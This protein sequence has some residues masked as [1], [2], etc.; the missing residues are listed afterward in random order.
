M[1]KYE[2]V[3]NEGIYA[4]YS[5]EESAFFAGY[6]FMGG[7]NWVKIPDVNC[8][9]GMEEA[10]QIV[11][12][13]EAADEPEENPAKKQYLFKV[14]IED[15]LFISIKTGKQI[16]DDYETDQIAGIYSKM[17]VWDVSGDPKRISLL[18]LVEP[19]LENK[20]WMEQEYRD[21]CEAERYG[22]V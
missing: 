20:R 21:Y 2:I 17:E 4:I 16:A 19:I 11:L 15:E 9:M 5:S 22:E 12:D 14:W 7:V 8:C 13:L 10:K 1:N 18:D 6:D 3:N